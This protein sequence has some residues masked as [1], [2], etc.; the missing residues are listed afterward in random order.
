MGPLGHGD[1]D[2]AAAAFPQP[3]LNQGLL[4]Q[5]MLDEQLGGNFHR[6][7]LAVVLFNHPLQNDTVVDGL[8]IKNHG[9]GGIAKAADQFSGAHLKQLH[10]CHPL[11]RNQGN[12]VAADGAIAKAHFLTGCEG[13]KPLQL[14]PNPGRRFK[15]QALCIGLHLL[16]QQVEQFVIASLEHHRHLPQGLV[17]VAR[18]DLLLTDPWAAADVEVQAGAIPIK[19]L[20]PLPQREDPFHQGQGAPQEAH[21]HVGAVK[22][23][24]G[25]TKAP[26]AGNK[27]SRIVFAPGNAKIGVFFVVFK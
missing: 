4:G 21:I 7:H 8:A 3:V 2:L 11:I 19:R 14:I 17:V 15:I 27:D 10:R 26:L 16:V 18:T 24:E 5:G 25:A 6:I 1:L 12:H 9:I 22:T 13:V 20:G 23:I